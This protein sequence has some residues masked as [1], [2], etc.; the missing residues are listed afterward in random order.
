MAE[1]WLEEM[2]RQ[3]AERGQFQELPG[4]GKPLRKEQL[5]ADPYTP[6]HLRLTHKVLKDND[7][8]PAWMDQGK[9]LDAHLAKVRAAFKRVAALPSGEQAAKRAELEERVKAYNRVA[10]TYNLKVPQGVTHKP[11]LRVEDELRRAAGTK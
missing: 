5:E 1:S 3:A 6:E 8:I 4:Q 2:L 9:E 11:I 10:L 7:F